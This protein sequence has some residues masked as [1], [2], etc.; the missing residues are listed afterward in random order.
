MPD[1]TAPEAREVHVVADVARSLIAERFPDVDPAVVH[2]EKIVRHAGMLVGRR[3]RRWP[4]A[5]IF[6]F[7]DR[8]ASPR[9]AVGMVN[10]MAQHHRSRIDQRAYIRVPCHLKG[11]AAKRTLAHAR[12]CYA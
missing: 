3:R 9:D 12:V 6:T 5:D 7:F 4:P 8:A 11:C 2:G 10:L 1:R